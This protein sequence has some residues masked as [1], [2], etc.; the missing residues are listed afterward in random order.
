MFF[1]LLLVCNM[2]VVILM[3][4]F[5]MTEAISLAVPLAFFPLFGILRGVDMGRPYFG[6]SWTNLC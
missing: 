2:V 1:L 5:W 3:S 6:V 4:L